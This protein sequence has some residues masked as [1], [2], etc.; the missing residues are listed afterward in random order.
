[1]GEGN[2]VMG[3]KVKQLVGVLEGNSHWR[4]ELG[5]NLIPGKNRD[6]VNTYCKLPIVKSFI[7][8]NK[9]SIKVSLG[10]SIN[11]VLATKIRTKVLKELSHIVT[12]KSHPTWGSL[13]IKVQ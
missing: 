1:M 11:C 8:Y 6:V 9:K 10:F 13:D 4:R 5:V 2:G 12:L 3:E 7:V